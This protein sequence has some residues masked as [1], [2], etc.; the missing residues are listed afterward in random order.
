[1][2][3]RYITVVSAF[4]PIQEIPDETRKKLRKNFKPLAARRLTTLP[5]LLGELTQSAAPQPTDEWVFASE[6]GGSISLEN[7]LNS[8]PNPSPLHFQNSIQPGPIDLVNVARGQA[9]NQLT[10]IVGGEHLLGD[11]L[12]TAMISPAKTV[13]LVGGEEFT[14]WAA[15]HG[16]G[17][18][19][20]FG[21]YLKI[22]PSEE[23]AVAEL[24]LEP[25]AGDT[26]PLTIREA[27]VRLDKRE[28]LATALSNGGLIRLQWR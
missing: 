2:N 3:K 15:T 17:A 19:D 28:S 8:F 20:S 21:F 23:S 25:Q 24:T 18:D 22:C 13:H 9:A 5:L 26:P 4:A 27:A 11:A 12:L 1:M 14:A 7:Y 16:L 6:F 10:P